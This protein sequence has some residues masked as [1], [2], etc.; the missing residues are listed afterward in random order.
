MTRSMMISSMVYPKHLLP[1]RFYHENFLVISS[2]ISSPAQA[3]IL[4]SYLVAHNAY[5]FCGVRG[6]FMFVE[7]PDAGHMYVIYKAIGDYGDS[8]EKYL[9]MTNATK[10]PHEMNIKMWIAWMMYA[11]FTGQKIQRH[12]LKKGYSKGEI[13]TG[14]CPFGFRCDQRDRIKT[15]VFY[16]PELFPW[17]INFADY[18]EVVLK[19]D[20]LLLAPFHMVEELARYLRGKDYLI[21]EVIKGSR[22]WIV[23]ILSSETEGTFVHGFKKFYAYYSPELPWKVDSN[24]NAASILNDPDAAIVKNPLHWGLKQL[25]A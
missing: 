13:I 17:E 7:L 11:G 22:H 5:A 8:S 9:I 1:A 6:E 12:L 10:S 3:A 24:I 25:V 15:K 20:A 16:K 19:G 14:M 18:Y 21:F 23:V 2:H 4:S